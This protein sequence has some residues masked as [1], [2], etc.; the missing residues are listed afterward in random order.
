MPVVDRMEYPRKYPLA[1]SLKLI[2]LLGIALGIWIHQYNQ[3]QLRESV[4]LS[5]IRIVDYSSGHIELAY[6]AKN[7]RSRDQELRLLAK[8]WD[9]NGEEIASIMFMVNL[10]AGA[11]QK[12]S[13]VIDKL[14]RPIREGETPHGAAIRVYERKIW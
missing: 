10:K 9:D 2:V 3:K 8:V 14:T 1:N 4:V 11:T 13:K 6:T 5:D 12:R 7:L